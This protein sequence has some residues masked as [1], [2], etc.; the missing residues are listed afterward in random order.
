M[1]FSSILVLCEVYFVF[2]AHT[3]TDYSKEMDFTGFVSGLHIGNIFINDSDLMMMGDCNFIQ[4]DFVVRYDG[5]TLVHLYL[6]IC[7][8]LS[9]VTPKF[10]AVRHCYGTSLK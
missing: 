1:I 10:D 7:I 5:W 6:P 4:E 8:S 3:H 9:R 2:S